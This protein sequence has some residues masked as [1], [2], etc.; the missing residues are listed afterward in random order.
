MIF[1]Y[2]YL[3]KNIVKL[4]QSMH[5]KINYRGDKIEILILDAPKNYDDLKKE[6]MHEI[7]SNDAYSIK[8]DKTMVKIMSVE[9]NQESVLS[10]I[11]SMMFSKM[12]TDMKALVEFEFEF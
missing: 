6:K 11:K 7:K 5:D 12:K 9:L 4:E 1:I 10:R 8:F 3:D 2:K